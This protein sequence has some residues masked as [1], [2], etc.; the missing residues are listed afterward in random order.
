MILETTRLQIYEHKWKCYWEAVFIQ[1]SR[2]ESREER[3]VLL[4]ESLRLWTKPVGI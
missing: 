1:D 4:T 2:K 3:K